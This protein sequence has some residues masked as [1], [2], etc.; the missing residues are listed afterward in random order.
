MQSFQSLRGVDAFY[1]NYND[2]LLLFYF[3]FF[4][5]STKMVLGIPWVWFLSFCACLAAF[6]LCYYGKPKSKANNNGEIFKEI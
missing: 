2:F 5:F 1:P 6:T 3:K 4:F